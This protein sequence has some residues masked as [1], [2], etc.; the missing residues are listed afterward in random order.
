[1]ARG[2]VAGSRRPEHGEDRPKRL[3]NTPAGCDAAA[4]GSRTGLE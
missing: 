2:R 1:M 4:S 3:L